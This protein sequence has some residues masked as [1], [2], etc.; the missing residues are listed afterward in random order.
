MTTGRAAAAVF[1]VD[2]T[3]CDTR[4]T[5]SL[6]LM[7]LRRRQHSAWR[8]RLWLASLGWRVPLLWLTDRF[9]RDASDR[10][11]Y[12]QFAGLSASQVADDAPSCCDEV[13]RPI[14]FREAVDE[15]AMHRRAGRRL[16]LVT[17]GV[18]VVL[19]PL[20][21]ALGAELLA[22]RL[23]TAGGRFT[24]DYRGYQVLGDDAPSTGQAARKAA[25]LKKYA[26]HTGLDLAAS[27]AY[28]DSVNDLAMLELVGTPVAVRPD[29][30][31]ARIASERGW[32]VRHWGTR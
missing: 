32:E 21:S 29:R 6:A 17:G 14:C 23:V 2:G 27:F 1:D 7:W 9:S 12:R 13:L 20:A 18:D 30:R 22:Q 8:H 31:L 16:V 4:S 28:G 10:Q 3:I 25:A 19:A 15:M 26:E 11:V 24:G 5:M